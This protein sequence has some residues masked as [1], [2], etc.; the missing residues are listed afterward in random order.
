MVR[1]VA[2][3]L[4]FFLL[5]L[6][7]TSVL[8]FI[9]TRILPGDVAR[10]ILG[11][12]ASDASV[13]ALREKLGL[14]RPLAQQ[15]ID[16]AGNFV[17]GDWGTMFS[18]AQED[19][20]TVVWQ[21]MV[22]SGWLAALTLLIAVPSAVVLGVIA[23]LTEGR[24]PDSLISI[25]SLSVVSLPEFVTGLFLI[26]TVALRWDRN[27][28]ADRLGWFPAS[29]F[30]QSGTS[31]REALPAL[32]L[33]AVAAALVLIAYMVRLIRAGVIEELKRDYVR[34]A[35]L[36]GL[37]YRTVVF[38]H[39]LRNA[40]IP[41]ITVVATSTGWLMSGL[42]VV[43]TVF[44]YP[45]LGSLLVNTAIKN[46]DLL[47]IQAIVMVTVAVILIANFI[48]DMLYAVLNPRIELE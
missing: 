33:P 34:T 36:K 10:V 37:P 29:S 23:G 12:E 27:F 22:H 25:L 19:V 17:Q 7:L 31:F 28:L 45:G 35:V 43:E 47:L 32:W 20:R 18:G 14:N 5:T 9:L 15:Y 24:L 3:R 6:F 39:I 41:T 1:F 30:I 2:R 8:V 4:V 11:R 42:V 16:W 48:A 38:K 26:N 40:L 13:A 44:G 46:R 21:R